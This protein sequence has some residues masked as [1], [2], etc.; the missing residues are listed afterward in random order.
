MLRPYGS[1]AMA[2]PFSEIIQF[3]SLG[4]G[5]LM[6]LCFVAIAILFVTANPGRIFSWFYLVGTIFSIFGSATFLYANFQV[7]SA[8]AN[9]VSIQKYFSIG[10]GLSLVGGFLAVIGLFGIAWAYRR[11]T[12]QFKEP[13]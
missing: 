7:R 6:T 8:P 9:I 10:Q 2:F 11:M 12:R 4:S 1:Y 3:I 13:G 5:I